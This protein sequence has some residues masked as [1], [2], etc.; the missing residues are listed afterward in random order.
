[1]YTHTHSLVQLS[2]STSDPSFQ[3]S[4]LSLPL[5][6]NSKP[7]PNAKDRFA[8]KVGEFSS[9]MDAA[10]CLSRTL[11]C[12][13]LCMRLSFTVFIRLAGCLHGSC[14]YASM[15]CFVVCLS[16]V[17]LSSFCLSGK[18]SIHLFFYLSQSLCLCLHLSLS[19]QS[20]VIPIGLSY[21]SE[22]LSVICLSCFLPLCASHTSDTR[23]LF[24]LTG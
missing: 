18:V 21:F 8:G 2:K 17:G 23:S 22:I 16:Y 19:C 12:V 24:H 13:C 5:S 9:Y 20:D 15:F 7:T 4:H 10:V 6:P 11:L 14:Q 3:P 1:M